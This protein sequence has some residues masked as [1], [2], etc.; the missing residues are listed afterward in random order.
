MRIA[1]QGTIGRLE[2][3]ADGGGDYVPLVS[4]R[5]GR[6]LDAQELWAGDDLL[7]TF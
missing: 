3:D 6:G 4:I 1:D 7:V 5:D 2:V